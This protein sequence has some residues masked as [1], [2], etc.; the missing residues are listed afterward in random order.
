MTRARATKTAPAIN[1]AIPIGRL[2]ADPRRILGQKQLHLSEQMERMV[3]DFEG[4]AYA[5]FA[6]HQ[7]GEAPEWAHSL[8]SRVGRQTVTGNPH[9]PPAG[10][11]VKTPADASA[12]E[13]VGFFVTSH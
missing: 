5:R 8:A 7:P 3:R 4:A 9:A 11:R 1:P 2:L 13:A 6:N 10:A 12:T